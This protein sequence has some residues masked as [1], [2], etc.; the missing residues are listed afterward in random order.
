MSQNP[1]E[2]GYVDAFFDKLVGWKSGLTP[3][4]SR[5]TEHQV[6][7]PLE[8][9]EHIKLAATVYLAI[10]KANSQVLGTIL[11]QCPYGRRAPL[12]ILCARIWAARGYHVLFV[13]TQGS[14]GSGGVLDPARTD[15]AD[16]PRVVRWMRKQS[17]YTGSF[18]TWGM[19]YLG[20]AQWALLAS[21]EPLDDMA[22]AIISVGPHDFS[23][24]LWGTGAHW[25]AS[26]DW[27]QMLRNQ[28]S[29]SWWRALY[30]LVNADPNKNNATKKVMPLVDGVKPLLGGA[31]S[32]QYQFVHR[33]LT[34]EDIEKDETGLWE[35]MKQHKALKRTDVPILLLAGWQDIFVR[36]NLE[37]FEQLKAN[38]C[39]VGLTV[40]P[41]NHGEVGNVDGVMQ[42]V[43]DWLD[44][45]LAKSSGN[46]RQAPVRVEITG[47]NES[48]WL[49]SWPPA[50]K[51]LELYLDAP[52][53]LCR[54]SPE[55]I[56]QAQFTFD[57]H[58]P[59]PTMGGGL[60]SRGGYVDDSALAKRADV[61]SFDLLVDEDVEII[62]RPR[63]H[64]AH[65]S[66]NPHVDVF[67]RLSEV[68]RKG[69]S[70]NLCEV[71]RR[72]DA[73]STHQ[74]GQS[75]IIEL[76]L[77]PFAHFFKKGTKIRL[78]VAGGNFPHY[79]YNLGSGE[80]QATGTTLRPARH[81]IHTGGKEGSKLI[82]PVSIH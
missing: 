70:R 11:V 64:L 71:Y 50:T 29:L 43:L 37:Q 60:L 28:E 53:K 81:T 14:F 36:Q 25:L 68:N 65:S 63:V 9:E 57:P 12:S 30:E 13:S 54:S 49:S 22:A 24:V 26:V 61:L 74:P 23:E 66:D 15:R 78:L 4:R 76:E 51:P 1:I 82:L 3:E 45:Y 17:W 75:E 33:W 80:A 27:A 67:V 32:R 6:E 41:W 34:N 72:L 10:P 5:Y 46:K 47:S 38:G 16:G 55:N 21:D 52:R 19:S 77:S 40:G 31:E 39:D 18:A 8:G 62:G 79:S 20:Y 58:E 56:D 35:P 59:T 42:E 7:I 44:K 73:N 69:V 2:R 48:R